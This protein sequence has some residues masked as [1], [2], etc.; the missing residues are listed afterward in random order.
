[1]RRRAFIAVL[2]GAAVWPSTALMQP[3]KLPMIGFLG[4]S[5][6]S[7]ATKRV[8]AFS[9]R[10][11][12]LGWIEGQTVAIDYRWADGK[13][14]RFAEIATDFAKHNVDVIVTWGTATALAAKQ[15]TSIIPIVF[16]IVSDPVGSGLVSS[17]ARPSGNATGLSTEQV[18][19]AGK[20]LEF[21][22]EI[23]PDL[24]AVAV[25]ANVNNAGA[26]RETSELEAAA[27]SLG[28]KV[29]QLN[30]RRSADIPI[31]VDV[32]GQAQG[33]F[34]ASDSL[35][36]NY[37]ELINKA[38]LAA[39]LPTVYGFRDP[40]EAGGLIGYGPEYLDLFRRAADYVDKILRGA[41]PA[42]IPIE[43]PT[44]FEL[45]INM[46]TANILGL[47]IPSSLLA[48]ADEVIE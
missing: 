44:K 27:R 13:A 16:T 31:A 19:I 22:R 28:V 12:E 15:A 20:R 34:V 4:P 47:T 23:V 21:L 48:R 35:F 25:L 33:L 1:M 45:V 42:D 37:R 26:M 40:I 9:Q 17:L 8:A 3:S 2:G 14:D 24:S 46:R 43:Q 18:D 11:R 41:K 5:T 6:A 10:L 39:R 38:A 36:N 29:I 30:V 7:V 32:R